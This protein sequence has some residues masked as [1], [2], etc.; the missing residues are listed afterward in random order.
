M[1]ALF[2]ATKHSLPD[3]T[4]RLVEIGLK[5]KGKMS[6]PVFCERRKWGIAVCGLVNAALTLS[7]SIAAAA[8]IKPFDLQDDR[9]KISISGNIA[10]GDADLLQALIK[11]ANDAGN[12]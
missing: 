5:A 6:D 9:V 7:V 3:A 4:R 1:A 2:F 11:A 12:W 10:P 8:E